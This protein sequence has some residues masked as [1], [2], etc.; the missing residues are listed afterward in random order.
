M[1]VVMKKGLGAVIKTTQ[2]PKKTG[3]H[4]RDFVRG[5]QGDQV[6]DDRMGNKK[7]LCSKVWTLLTILGTVWRYEP[8]I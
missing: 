4:Y 8:K 2:K 5:R 6:T 7:G 1:G 3:R